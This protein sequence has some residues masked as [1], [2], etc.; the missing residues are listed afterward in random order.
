MNT[1]ADSYLSNRQNFSRLFVQKEEKNRASNILAVFQGKKGAGKVIDSTIV[2]P[3]NVQEFLVLSTNMSNLLGNIAS[4]L[5]NLA[6]EE[7]LTSVE[8]YFFVVEYGGAKTQ[9]LALLEAKFHGESHIITIQFPTLHNI[10]LESLM[11]KLFTGTLAYL[12]T[13]RTHF[14]LRDPNIIEKCFTV[15]NNVKDSAYNNSIKEEALTIWKKIYDIQ[16]LLQNNNDYLRLR[17]ILHQTE[18]IDEGRAVK[19]IIRLM[20]LGTSEGAVYLFLFDEI[21]HWLNETN[22][23]PSDIFLEKTVLLQTFLQNLGQTKTILFF[24]STP[25]VQQAILNNKHLVDKN[26]TLSRLKLMMHNG[27]LYKENLSFGEDLPKVAGKLTALATYIDD[28]DFLK[29]DPI[30]KEFLDQLQHYYIPNNKHLSKRDA[31]GELM[32]L[33]KDFKSIKGQIELGQQIYESGEW[34]TGIGNLIHKKFHLIAKGLD[35]IFHGEEPSIYPGETHTRRLDGVF[36]IKKL[37]PTTKE[38]VPHYTAVEI[39]TGKDFRR[40]K[41][42]QALI[43]AGVEQ[44]PVIIIWFGDSSKQEVERLIMEQAVKLGR[45]EEANLVKVVAV[46]NPFAFVPILAVAK[47]QQDEHQR[48]ILAGKWL[49]K[50]SPIDRELRQILGYSDRK[51]SSPKPKG[52]GEG[53]G[54]NGKPPEETPEE[55]P[56]LLELFLYSWFSDRST[57]VKKSII[58]RDQIQEILTSLGRGV[59]ELDEIIKELRN[60][61]FVKG[62]GAKQWKLSDELK[63]HFQN[64]SQD[65]FMIFVTQKVQGTKKKAG[66]GSILS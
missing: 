2:K 47:H 35:Y 19:E 21:D 49:K 14:G 22:E 43:F 15:L 13:K 26:A 42:E 11:E 63:N 17:D 6:K 27:A 28:T 18:I 62:G 57:W 52:V 48:M 64:S 66:L 53:A 38:L 36:E 31:I 23:A 61:K 50:F 54:E 39:K 16:P 59:S 24:C 20:E 44:K 32:D 34:G 33:I 1:V 30:G 56:S 10:N 40:E 55:P 58:K 25:Y 41:A 45:R 9:T 29:R 65:I 46:N 60:H 5:S 37:D 51:V 3:E 12:T 4:D 8:S 7:T